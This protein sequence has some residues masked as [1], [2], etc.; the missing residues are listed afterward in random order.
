M[1]AS[2]FDDPHAAQRLS[3]EL[4]AL[5]TRNG[6]DAY[7]VAAILAE[8]AIAAL[9]PLHGRH[10]AADMLAEAVAPP[11]AGPRGMI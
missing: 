5:A 6:G 11:P 10:E 2:P 7:Q 4:V 1:N 8:A 3:R 9:E